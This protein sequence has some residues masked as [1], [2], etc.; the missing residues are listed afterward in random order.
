MTAS[1]GKAEWRGA[2]AGDRRKNT[3]ALA[4]SDR[5]G[6][7]GGGRALDGSRSFPQAVGEYHSLNLLGIYS[8]RSHQLE[9]P[10]FCAGAQKPKLKGLRDPLW[11]SLGVNDDHP[12]RRDPEGY[13]GWNT[14]RTAGVTSHHAC[15]R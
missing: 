3:T 1:R 4:V 2:V 11:D 15:P 14:T 10:G 7:E 8:V 12:R 9:K 5:K 13:A 6:G